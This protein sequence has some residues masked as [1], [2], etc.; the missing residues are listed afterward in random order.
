MRDLKNTCFVCKKK[1]TS[2][3]S[4]LN[5]VV[6]LPVCNECKGSDAEKKEEKEVLDSLADGFVCGCI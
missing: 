1:I 3:N 5:P 2:A 4:E 6:N